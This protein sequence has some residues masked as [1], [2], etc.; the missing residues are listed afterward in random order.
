MS[1]CGFVGEEIRKG[2]VVEGLVLFESSIYLATPTII[3]E[4]HM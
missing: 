3:S 4:Q 2:T 1:V